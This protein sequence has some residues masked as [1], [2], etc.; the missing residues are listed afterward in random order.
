MSGA[1]PVQV[2]QRLVIERH[3]FGGQVLPQVSDGAGPGDEQHVES[4]LQQPLE[5]DLRPA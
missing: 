5:R 1:D 3:A 4:Q 2:A